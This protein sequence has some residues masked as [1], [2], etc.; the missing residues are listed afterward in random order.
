[1]SVFP[2]SIC[3]RR[4][5]GKQARAYWAWFVADGSRSAWSVRYCPE[6]AAEHLAGLLKSLRANSELE[7]VFSC[8]LC[9]ADASQDSDPLY[10]TLYVPGRPMEEMAIQACSVCA[11][12]FRGPITQT[13]TRLPDRGG[14]VRGP[15]PDTS[16]WDKLGL[17]PST[18]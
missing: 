4:L 18:D 11:A 16:V 7:D 17:A 8:I 1:M 3:R 15:S 13:G 5:P 14:L 9:G 12:K 6:C 10:C 2:C